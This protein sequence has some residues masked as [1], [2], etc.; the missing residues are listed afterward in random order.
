[1]QVTTDPYLRTWL[2]AEGYLPLTRK[3]TAFL[4]LQTGIN[5]DYSRHAMN[6]FVV[7]GM[8]KLYRNQVIFAGLQ[9]GTIYTPAMATIQ[10]GLRTNLFTGAYLSARA[11]VLF[12][13]FISRSD[14][15]NYEDIYSGYALT[16]SYNFALGPLDLSLMY[17]DQTKKIQSYINLG[18][19]F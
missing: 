15:F 16:F 18:I 2:A 14:F 4:N 3:L 9:E 19:P 17:C 1:M 13:N 10:G 6:E 12:N 8:T 5:F 7:G 11:N